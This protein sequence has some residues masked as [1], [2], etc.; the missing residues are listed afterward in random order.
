METTEDVLERGLA[1]FYHW[2]GEYLRE[3]LADSPDPAY[4]EIA[5][6]L[7]IPSNW[8]EWTMLAS[9]MKYPWTLWANGWTQDKY[10]NWY[11]ADYSYLIP[12]NPNATTVQISNLPYDDTISHFYIYQK[13][14]TPIPGVYPYKG[15]LANKKWPLKK[16]LIRKYVK[17][18]FDTSCCIFLL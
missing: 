3:I 2:E 12:S 13:S 11:I 18:Y 17:D 15:H 5:K 10:G 16:V 1:P 14:S 4:Q 8:Y 7:I 6:R 9:Q